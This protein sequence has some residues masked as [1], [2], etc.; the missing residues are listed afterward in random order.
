MTW[1]LAPPSFWPEPHDPWAWQRALRVIAA[2]A[3]VPDPW[4]CWRRV[5]AGKLSRRSVMGL[6]GLRPD[7]APAVILGVGLLDRRGAAEWS[8]SALGRELAHLDRDSFTA[9]LADA[10]VRRSAW[11]RLALRDLAAGRWAIPRG[12]APLTAR[13]QLRVN[14]HLVVPEHALRQLPQP[15]I[16]LGELFS[17]EVDEVQTKTPIAALSALHAPLYLLHVSGWLG[18]DGRPRLSDAHAAS[19]QIEPAAALLRRIT[20]EEQ[21]PLGFAPIAKIAGRL[22]SAVNGNGAARDLAAWTD[23]VLGGA[24]DAGTIEVHAWAAGQPRHGRGLHGDRDRKLVRW[25]IHDDFE[26]PA[27]RAHRSG[28][29][30]P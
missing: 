14:E 15:R 19:L 10:L 1:R 26:L 5:L 3:P 29:A 30:E 28:E 17:A 6:Y 20:T 8:L 25:T 7:P 27:A 11:I 21:D 22:W 18:A 2:A 13:R 9:G 24:I 16:L 12:V 4:P 23:A